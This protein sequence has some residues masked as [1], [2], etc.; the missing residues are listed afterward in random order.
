LKFEI[1]DNVGSLK[2]IYHAVF[3]A[4]ELILGMGIAQIVATAQVFFSNRRLF[5]QMSAVADAGFLPV[6]N[7]NVLPRLLELETAFCGGML[8][9]LSVGAGL[10]L[11]T[12]AAARL[13]QRCVSGRRA[14]AAALGAVLAGGVVCLNLH[15]FDPWATLYFIAIPPPVFWLA[16]RPALA[17]EPPAPPRLAGLRCLPLVLLAL[18]WSTQY[19]P[20]LFIDLRDHLLMSNPVGA[21]VSSFYYRYT[22]YPAEV[23]KTLD[24][25]LIKTLAVTP[26]D[27][28]GRQPALTRELIR[29]D[30]LPVRGTAAAEVSL[31]IEAGRLAFLHAGKT[32]W[33]DASERFLSDPRRAAADISARADRFAFFR[34]VAYYGVLLAFPAALYVLAFALLRLVCGAATG[35]RRAD[36]VAAAA[37]LL[38]GFAILASFHLGRERPP[39]P[40]A[41]G[42][43]LESD[44]WQ[45]RVAGL[46]EAR[47]HN[48]DLAAVPGYA[49][50]LHSPYPQERYWLAR[51]LAVS[52]NPGASDDLIR[53]L[54]DPQIN[55]RTMALEALG[56]RRDPR[57]VQPILKILKTSDEWYDQLYAYQ[58]LRTLRWDQTRLH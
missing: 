7:Q 52:P 4:T 25:R 29:L 6:P 28:V 3:P 36:A 11:L 42:A 5:A 33:A 20:G 18:G 34:R 44:R 9:T 30:Y 46:K 14:A 19:D 47:A 22:L 55:V 35:G 53:M 23:F 49:A 10:S 50:M 45:R 27:A 51:A 21:S 56:E 32:V 15:G 58:A 17:R 38:I 40:Q 2:L 54:G 13:W 41:I 1:D 48:I 16:A 12:V 43:A 31:R 39:S 8:F 24:Q 26:A 37:C 57:A